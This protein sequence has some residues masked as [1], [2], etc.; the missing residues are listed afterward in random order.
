MNDEKPC[1]FPLGILFKGKDHHADQ[2]DKEHP[3]DQL[4]A[5]KRNK[6]AARKKKELK[7]R[8]WAAYKPCW[9]W[10]MV[11]QKVRIKS[12]NKQTTV[13]RDELK[14]LIIIYFR[15]IDPSNFKKLS[16][17][18]FTDPMEPVILTKTVVLS[19][20]I[21]AAIMLLSE[22]LPLGLQGSKIKDFSLKTILCF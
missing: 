22:G 18:C 13:M 21:M 3:K 9:T 7:K 19:K 1:I 16:L 6:P 12:R 11:P 8:S 2:I 14:N 4:R 10:A 20:A 5:G 17:F 15:V